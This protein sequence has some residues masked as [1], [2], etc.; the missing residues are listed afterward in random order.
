MGTGIRGNSSVT[1]GVET[2]IQPPSSEQRLSWK[3]GKHS[4]RSGS[5]GNLTA[6]APLVPG[7]GG[8]PPP[9]PHLPPL[10]RRLE[11]GGLAWPCMPGAGALSGAREQEGGHGWIPSF[12]FSPA[13]RLVPA[14]PRS[15]GQL[16]PP[17]F[18]PRRAAAVAPAAAVP[19][20]AIGSPKNAFL[21]SFCAVFRNVAGWERASS[22]LL[23]EKPQSYQLFK[24]SKA[25]NCGERNFRAEA[26]F[27]WVY[28]AQ[29]G[30]AGN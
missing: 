11:E 12:C 23:W 1:E 25:A 9:P 8:C 28:M 15:H 24:E 4:L 2:A 21:Q 6:S 10:P 5:V 20:A 7:A 3:P 29:Q 27:L 13:L 17:H 19:I 16:S 14:P 22:P 26:A 30:N 18:P